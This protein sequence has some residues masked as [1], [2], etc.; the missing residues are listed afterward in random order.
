MSNDVLE[1]NDIQP[2]RRFLTSSEV[3]KRRKVLV[4]FTKRRPPRARDAKHMI[5]KSRCSNPRG[6][7]AKHGVMIIININV[8]KEIKIEFFKNTSNES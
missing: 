8:A 6:Y 7:F 1:P 5:L 2:N 4:S 3:V